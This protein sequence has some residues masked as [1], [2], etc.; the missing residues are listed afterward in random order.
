MNLIVAVDNKWGIG[1]Q[2]R[3]LF[4]ISDDLKRFRSL[5]LGKTVILGR[6]TLQTFPG[7]RPLDKRTNIILTR[8]A[9]FSAEPAIICHSVRELAKAIDDMKSENIFV[10]GGA[11]VYRQL[12]PYC[13][14]AYVTKIDAEGDADC[15]LTDLDSDPDWLLESCE[16][17]HTDQAWSESAQQ[18]IS[19]NYSFC[20]Y[21]QL[22]PRVLIDD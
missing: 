16:Q 10:I 19:L 4:R 8:S 2:D 20:L 15:V 21:R 1:R 7:G 13:Q 6:R 3:L 18:P 22:K 14:Y 5:T 12:L 9:D 17:Y 11:M